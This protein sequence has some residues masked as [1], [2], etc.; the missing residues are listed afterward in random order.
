M[1]S[2]KM[3]SPAEKAGTAYLFVVVAAGAGALVVPDAGVVVELESLQA[4]SRLPTTS[5]RSAI[6]IY[7]RFIGGLIFYHTR[8]KEQA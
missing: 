1:P 2:L 6:T 4:V 5:V 3:A 7:A 8:A